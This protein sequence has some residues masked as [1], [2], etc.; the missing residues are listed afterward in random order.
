MLGDICFEQADFRKE[1]IM[2]DEA[3]QKL[4]DAGVDLKGA[5]ER[6]LNNEAM[7]EKFLK[8]FLADPNYQELTAA[9]EEKDCKRAFTASHTLKGVCG[10]LAL[11][12]LYHAITSQV[13]CFRTERFEEGAAMMPAVSA[14]YDK[15]V[16]LITTIFP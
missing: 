10:N 4:Q 7:Y 12:G 6:F 1:G 11:Q 3:K 9:V 8:K 2:T 13:E 5:M 15:V 14:E 16:T